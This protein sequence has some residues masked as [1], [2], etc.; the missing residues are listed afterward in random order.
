MGHC[1]FK[2]SWAFLVHAPTVLDPPEAQK[3]MKTSDEYCA[4][5]QYLAPL[6]YC[7][8]TDLLHAHCMYLKGNLLL[9]SRESALVCALLAPQWCSLW[10]DIY[11]PVLGNSGVLYYHDVACPRSH[12]L[13]APLVH[14]LCVSFSGWE[15]EFR[16][17]PNLQPIRTFER[18]PFNF[19][20]YTTSFTSVKFGECRFKK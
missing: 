15:S 19:L 11:S 16:R 2:C 3:I 20:F 10:S 17:L 6:R 5:V 9:V 4:M 18:K 12:S 14:L 7:G 8:F 13:W 1:A